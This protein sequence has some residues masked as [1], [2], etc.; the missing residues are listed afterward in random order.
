MWGFCCGW[1]G[2]G[3]WFFVCG[4]GVLLVELCF[5]FCWVWGGLGLWFCVCWVCVLVGWVVG[6]GFF[7][8]WVLF[9]FGFFFFV[10]LCGLLVGVG[11]SGFFCFWGGGGLVV[12]F[13]A[14]VLL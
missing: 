2:L 11:V 7:F 8:G 5:C 3:W 14:V 10:F 13:S 6:L 12:G 4:V 1:V 9:L